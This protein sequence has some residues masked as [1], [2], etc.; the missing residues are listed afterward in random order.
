[1]VFLVTNIIIKLFNSFIYIMNKFMVIIY[2]K[3][4]NKLFDF[5]Q[6]I[7]SSFFI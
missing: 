1:M 7:I 3:F 4:I 2:F 6:L 5:Y